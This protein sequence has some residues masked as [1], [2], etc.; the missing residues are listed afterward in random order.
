[1]VRVL[2]IALLAFAALFVV[3]RN[4]PVPEPEPGAEA[5]ATLHDERAAPERTDEPIIPD[6]PQAMILGAAQDGGVPHLGCT[7]E[8]CDLAR[9]DASRVVRVASLGLIVPGDNAPDKVFLIDAKRRVRNIYSA[10]FL[11][12][13]LLLNDIQTVLG[14]GLDR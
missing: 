4:L 10:G 3:T 14:G 11:S 1:M 6:G 7:Q 5:E 9:Q 13:Q 8:F 12:W 2:A